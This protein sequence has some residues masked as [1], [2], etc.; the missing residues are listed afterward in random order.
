V[1][2]T[3]GTGLEPGCNGWSR[4]RLEAVA[5]NKRLVNE[6]Y[7]RAGFLAYAEGSGGD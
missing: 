2:S 1:A 5:A 7:E 4:R 6:Q 3:P